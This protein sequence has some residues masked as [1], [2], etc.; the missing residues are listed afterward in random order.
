LLGNVQASEGGQ[1]INEDPI[2]TNPINGRQVLTAGNDYNCSTYTG[3]F[4]SS[5]GGA[6]WSHSCLGSQLGG[7]GDPIVGYDLHGT[8]YAGG[9]NFNCSEVVLETSTDNGATW[10]APAVA[11]PPIVGGGSV[12]KP[13]LQVDTNPSSPH[14][15]TV[16]IS[17][18]QFVFGGIE[19]SVS[20]SGDGG[21]T[22][23]TTAVDNPQVSN[24]EQFSD[25]AIGKDGTVYVSWLRCNNPCGGGTG[26]LL[27]SRSTDGGNTWSAPATIANVALSPGNCNGF[28]GCLP[29]TGERVSEIPA[30]GIDNSTGP[31]AGR[32]YAALYN[33]TGTYMEVEVASSTDGGATWA[34]PV[35]VSP[36]PNAHDQFFPWLSVSNGG[37]VGVTWLDRRDDP[38]NI[39][40][41]TYAAVSTNGGVSFTSGKIGSALSNPNNDGFGGTFM[42][43][44]TGNTWVGKTLAASWMD[45]RNGVNMQDEVGGVATG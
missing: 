7:C 21:A 1:P 11:V 24:P 44:Y 30:I 19:I 18:T 10:S 22:W 39:S 38:A 17:A 33:W 45:S 3:F 37:A 32:L 4:A 5:N 41:T 31:F 15:N 29:H 12:D 26:T 34:T 25:L 9:L 40:Y 27:F 35:P 13:W 36:S 6:T 16:Y 20:H 23:T 43:D 14:A 28:Y 42:G 8:A 2:E